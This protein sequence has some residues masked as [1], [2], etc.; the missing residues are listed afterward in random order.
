MNQS[1]Q[2]LR[3]TEI[4]AIITEIQSL[5]IHVSDD[6]QGRKVGAGPAEGKSFVLAAF[7]FNAPIS[8][9]YVSCS[10]FR[11]EYRDGYLL[12]KNETMI[13][14][15]DIVPDPL[16]YSKTTRDGIGLRNIALLHGKDCIATTV[17]QRCVHWK[18]LEKCAFCSTETS[19]IKNTTIARK[20]PEQLVD[21]ALAA[22]NL[23]NVTHFVLTSGT[24]DPP[25]SEIFYL[26]E[27]THAI[28]AAVDIPIQVQFAPPPS[29]EMIDLLKDSG[30]ESVG[31][32]IESFDENVLTRFAPAKAKIGIPY[33]KKCWEKAVESF[34]PNQVSSFLIAGLGESPKSILFGSELLADMGVYPF[35]VPL[36]PLPGST[37]E[38]AFPP[39]PD[40]MKRLYEAVSGILH[41]KGLASYRSLA[42]CVRCGA[43]SALAAYE[44]HGA[45]T[46]ICH[47]ARNAFE[48][49]QAFRIRKQVFVDEQQLFCNSDRDEHDSDAIFIVAE[50]ANTIVGTVRIYPVKSEPGHWIGGRLAVKKAFRTGRTGSMLVKEAMKRVKNSGCTLFTADIQE[51]NVR[52]FKKLGWEATGPLTMHY[53]IPHQPMRANLGLILDD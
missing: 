25:G 31:I 16:F 7:P 50:T 26:A 15:I 2:I 21:V 37:L 3:N 46:I 9:H 41:K 23:D 10:P 5:G 49:N 22:H 20:T 30:V 36:R 8:A 34:G 29:L 14:P 35:V 47:T 33:Y 32:H 19:L 17:L 42:G 43:C 18:N 27:C 51:K 28:K 4:R 40:M 52:F 12:Y 38:K 6:I 1:E 39:K 24:A 53:G 44:K 48:R 45:E 13:S 11:L